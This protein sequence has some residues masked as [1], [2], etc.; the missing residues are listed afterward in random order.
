RNRVAG[1]QQHSDGVTLTIATPDG[2]YQLNADWVVACD[3]SRSPTRALM[4][5]DFAGEVFDD[6]FLI[7][8]VK[9]T[10]AFPTKRWFWFQ[11]PFHSG[12]SALLHK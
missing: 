3:G 7:A 5:L 8:D 12:Q 9:M 4:G 2:D 11:P 10:A 6:R 1:L